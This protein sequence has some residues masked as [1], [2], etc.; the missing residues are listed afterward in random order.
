MLAPT[1]ISYLFSLTFIFGGIGWTIATL[2]PIIFGQAFATPLLTAITM[3][4]IAL[5][6]LIWTL[7]ARKKIQPEKGKPKLDPILAARSAALAMSSSRVGAIALGFYAGICLDNLI[8][9]NSTASKE[10]VVI[11][12]LTAVAGLVMVIVGL[13][14]EHLCRISNPP[15]EPN[16]A[17]SVT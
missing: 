2:W 4:L 14:L 17:P 12:G 7:L 13:W 11:C 15:A 10:R 16:A 8:F 1:R 3:W 9:S 6:L 5:A